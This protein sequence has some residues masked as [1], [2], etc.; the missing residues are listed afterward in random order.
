MRKGRSS[1]CC[2]SLSR[3]CAISL[4]HFP[5]TE[6]LFYECNPCFGSRLWTSWITARLRQIAPNCA[7]LRQIAPNGVISSVLFEVV[8]AVLNLETIGLDWSF[9]RN[10]SH[11]LFARS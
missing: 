9:P 10:E 1:T 5:Q 7:K 6:F 8:L 2:G 4:R 3:N 11:P